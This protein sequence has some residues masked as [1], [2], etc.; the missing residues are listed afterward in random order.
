MISI[1]LFFNV[2]YITKRQSI[3]LMWNP[4]LSITISNNQYSHVLIKLTN[5]LSLSLDSWKRFN[6]DLL[7][8]EMP[9]N[10]WLCQ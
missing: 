8:I 6:K 3:G 4:L 5:Q 10:H 2:G 9:T 7:F 1:Y